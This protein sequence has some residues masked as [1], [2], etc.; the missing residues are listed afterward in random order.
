MGIARASDGKEGQL[1]DGCLD[2]ANTIEGVADSGEA[3][4][5]PEPLRTGCG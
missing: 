5:G 4:E 3:E 1:S 2:D